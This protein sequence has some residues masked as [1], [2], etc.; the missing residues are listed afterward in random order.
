M[1]LIRIDE[2]PAP[3]CTVHQRWRTRSELA[4]LECCGSAEVDRIAVDLGISAFELRTLASYGPNA[5]ELFKSPH[6]LPA[7]RSEPRGALHP[8]TLRDLQRLCTTC[9][10]RSSARGSYQFS[11]RPSGEIGRIGRTDCRNAATL[12][13][14]RRPR[15]LPCGDFVLAPPAQAQVSWWLAPT[16]AALDLQADESPAEIFGR[17]SCPAVMCQRAITSP[18][19]KAAGASGTNK[20]PPPHTSCWRLRSS[21]SPTPSML[22]QATVPAGRSGGAHHRGMQCRRQQVHLPASWEC[23]CRN[24]GLVFYLGTPDWRRCLWLDRFREFCA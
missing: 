8:F 22:A 18:N 6:R 1:L 11:R 13:T 21:A 7:H 23:R 2:R 12:T 3:A 19:L 9:R 20:I 24:F 16:V 5:A 15:Q 10:S 4:D 14:C 17:P